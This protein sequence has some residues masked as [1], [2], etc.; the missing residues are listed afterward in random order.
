MK[1]LLGLLLVS[2]MLVGC[3]SSKNALSLEEAQKIALEAFDGKVTQAR[4]EKDDGVS[5]YEF[6]ITGEKERYEIEVDANSGNILKQ[7]KD[8]DY[9][10]AS[11]SDTNTNTNTNTAATITQEQ[12][13]QIAMDRVGSGTLVK[14]ELESDDGILKYDVQIKNGNTEYD[15]DVDANSGEILKFDQDIDD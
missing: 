13:Q 11:N 9:V 2:I 4:E 5:Y 15:V 12:A 1:K 6:I 3:G 10:G 7:E 14:C 8:D